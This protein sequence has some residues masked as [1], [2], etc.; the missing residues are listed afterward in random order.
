MVVR[1]R[2]PGLLTV[3]HP[4]GYVIAPQLLV[5]KMRLNTGHCEF[6]TIAHIGPVLIQ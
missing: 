6:D 1:V 4:P 5:C 2:V 3:Q